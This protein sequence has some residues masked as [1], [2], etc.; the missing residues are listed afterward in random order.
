MRIYLA[1]PYFAR[2]YLRG[3]IPELEFSGHIVT[4]SW[5]QAS[6]A[7]QENTLGTAP[8]MDDS[9]ARD[10]AAQD[11]EEVL[12]S[13]ALI[14]FTWDTALAHC[15]PDQVTGPNSGGRHVETGVALATSIPVI[16]FGQPENIFHRGAG[17]QVC[18]RWEDVIETLD[19]VQASRARQSTVDPATALAVA[20]AEKQLEDSTESAS[21]SN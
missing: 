5:L 18:S 8:G 9:Y 3:Y 16:V 2:D 12:E 10:H 13:D 15:P 7:I 17:V 11:I 21:G 20:R 4:S 19:A 14:L 6:H 1:A